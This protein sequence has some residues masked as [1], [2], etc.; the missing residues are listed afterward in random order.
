MSDS[1]YPSWVDL[2]DDVT[3]VVMIAVAIAAIL[4]LGFDVVIAFEIFALGLLLTGAT[5]LVWGIYV[6]KTNT[7]A[8]AFMIVTGISVMGLSIIDFLF[9][10]LPVDFLIIFPA[11]GMI[12][13]GLSRIVLGVIV[14]DIPLWIQMLQV[15]AGILTLNLAAF[16]FIFPNVNLEILLIFLLIS[17]IANGLVRVII[18]RSIVPQKCA[19][20][21]SPQS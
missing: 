18:G 12:M 21:T 5:W 10:S 8:R 13:I 9:L 4:E 3:G 20:P 2:L 11:I 17:M 16:V 19:E 14:G 1:H 6:M 7:Y 15:L